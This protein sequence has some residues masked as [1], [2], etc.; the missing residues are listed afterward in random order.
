M[1]VEGAEPDTYEVVLF[2]PA[3]QRT[4]TRYKGPAEV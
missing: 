4:F 3:G 2:G 1:E